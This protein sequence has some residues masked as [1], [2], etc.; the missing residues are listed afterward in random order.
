MKGLFCA[1]YTDR[2]SHYFHTPKA[3]GTVSRTQLTQVGRALS[4]LGIEHIARFAV[5]AEQE[6]SAFVADRTG[7]APGLPE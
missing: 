2:A 4:Q 5:P 7:T 3:G 1:L 6:G